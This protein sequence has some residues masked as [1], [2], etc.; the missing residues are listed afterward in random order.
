MNVHVHE[1]VTKYMHLPANMTVFTDTKML[2]NSR[3]NLRLGTLC[4]VSNDIP[5]SVVVV[6]VYTPGFYVCLI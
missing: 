2:E 3:F 5:L 6:T 4:L 1:L